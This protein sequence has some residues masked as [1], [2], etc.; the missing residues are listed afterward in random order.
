[1]CS[2]HPNLKFGS[3]K[4]TGACYRFAAVVH[5]FGHLNYLI[6]TTTC[7][8]QILVLRTRMTV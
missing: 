5:N 3:G 6:L 8:I 7:D 1:M 2:D 4:D